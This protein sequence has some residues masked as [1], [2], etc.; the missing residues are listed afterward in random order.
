MVAAMR[1]EVRPVLQRVGRSARGTLVGCA[2][3]RFT[4][5]GFDCRLVLCGIGIERAR[6]AAA[7]LIETWKPGLLVSFGIAGGVEE[8]L[9]VGDVVIAREA[10]FL[11]S[12][13]ATQ[14][15]P[16]AQPLARARDAAGRVLRERGATLYEGST[17]TTR[18]SQALDISK[19]VPPR[20]V[21][22][23]ETHGVAREAAARGIPLLAVRAL[24]DSAREPLPFD[25]AAFTDS[26][27]HFHTGRLLL[28]IA[29][30]PRLLP[31]LL[32]LRRNTML[33]A[34]NAAVAV[35]ALLAALNEGD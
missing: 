4:L 10:A 34:E 8:D 19:G 17:V 13:I 11:E 33:A 21:L 30:H 1:Q 18:G 25:L 15:L 31:R 9:Q 12:E 22:D 29:S 16:L 20:P 26:E 23:M 32:M 5:S 3:W 2:T 6:A 28:H 14:R 35:F 27:Y 7:A 24:S